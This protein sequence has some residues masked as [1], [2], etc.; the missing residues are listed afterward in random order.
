VNP[1]RI[2]LKKVRHAAGL[3]LLLAAATLASPSFAAQ[4]VTLNWDSS[5]SADV[6]GYKIYYRD[7]SINYT[8][9]LLV[10][11]ATSATVSGLIEGETYFFTVT[12]YNAT[13]DLESDPSNE[14]SYT[15]PAPAMLAIEVTR[16]NGVATAVSVTASGGV[17]SQWV[18]ETSTDLQNWTPALHGT[19]APVNFSLPVTGLPAQFFR[20]KSEP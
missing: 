11:A 14:I 13:L 6:T 7:A 15:V 12:A 2:T 1:I 17:P 3:L 20:L 4:S 10:N 16:E 19:N 8:N 5:S 9:V 18:L